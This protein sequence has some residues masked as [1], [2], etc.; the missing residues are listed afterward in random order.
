MLRLSRLLGCS[1]VLATAIAIVPLRA[2]SPS[3]LSPSE[4]AAI[5]GGQCWDKDNSGPCPNPWAMGGQCEAWG[6]VLQGGVGPYVC[7]VPTGG[8]GVRNLVTGGTGTPK[9]F[10]SGAGW[11]DCDA[12]AGNFACLFGIN[13]PAS[14]VQDSFGNW[15]CRT[16]TQNFVAAAPGDVV[17]NPDC[18]ST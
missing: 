10:S 1:V 17:S 12:G 16:S 9:C 5:R 3:T 15:W 2:G 13:C 14:C 18:Y 7:G 8:T 6:C 4:M 11:F